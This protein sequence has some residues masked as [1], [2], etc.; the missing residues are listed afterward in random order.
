MSQQPKIGE[1]PPDFT[2]ALRRALD[3]R[4]WFA[5]GPA[6]VAVALAYFALGTLVDWFFSAYGFFPAP[7]WLPAAVA[8]AAAMAGEWRL[9]PGVFVGSF[10]TNALVF[11]APIY[12]T[13]IISITNA[14]GPVVGA[15]ALRRMRPEK[16]VFTSFGGVIRFLLCMMMV[17]PAISAIGGTIAML[18]GQPFSGIPKIHTLL[19]G[20]WLCDA[21]GTLYLAPVLVLWL[22][23]ERADNI[24]AKR[25]PLDRQALLVWLGVAAF[26]AF[27]F[28]TPPMPLNMFRQ[29]TPFL[30]VVPLSW[31]ALRVSLRSAYML[32]LF[33]A[34]VAAVGT[35]AGL[36]AF[37]DH[38]IANPMQMVETLV[39]LLA[40][41]V[42]TTVALVCELHEAQN[43]THVKSMF[44]ATTSHEL[45]SPLNAIIGF[46]SMIDSQAVGPIENEQYT[47]F[48]RMIHSAADHLLGL[49]NDLLDLSKIEAGRFQLTERVVV[50]AG[51]IGEVRSLTRPQAQA[52]SIIVST[53]VAPDIEAVY[54][55]P[56]ALRQ[57]LI[58]LVSNAIKFTPEGGRVDIAA[59]QDDRGDITLSVRDTGVGIPAD[60]IERLFVP[61]ERLERAESA[62]IEG[63]GLGLCVT[64]GL[65]QLHGGTIRLE[66]ELG[67]GTNAIVTLPATRLVVM[68]RGLAEAAD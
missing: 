66:S 34:I 12:V 18:I 45:R 46:S 22:G 63:T 64:R 51:A 23:L 55:D 9:F 50:V 7:I 48:A 15:I 62:A 6:N 10:L 26:S 24:L 17:S 67:R 16:G 58:N 35:V 29:M 38:A 44:L 8:V 33:V 36:G 40:M 49:I 54:A 41:D 3:E 2:P 57:I 53:D 60:G 32:V 20:W 59:A 14:L 30:L 19:V 27:L 43:D 61:F 5:W 68:E 13:T 11:G 56:R 42:L 37:H 25:H 47:D 31:V 28:L 1:A 39:V 4:G 52:K 65:V 21:G